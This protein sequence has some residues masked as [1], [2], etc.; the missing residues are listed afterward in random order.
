[1]EKY[2]DVNFPQY[3][4]L[5]DGITVNDFRNSGSIKFTIDS[6]K[7]PETLSE[8]YLY[9]LTTNG[10]IN[11][12]F[13]KNKNSLTVVQG[14]EKIDMMSIGSWFSPSK[15]EKMRRQMYSNFARCCTC[16]EYTKN[17]MCEE[18]NNKYRRFARCCTC[19]D[20]TQIY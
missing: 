12:I 20:G 17:C 15:Q 11:Y 19:I 5:P 9:S 10:L 18:R 13:P 7:V 14:L 8:E 6:S 3:I 1:M 16:N 2:P 4:K